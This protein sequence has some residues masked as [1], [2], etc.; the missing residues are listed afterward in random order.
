MSTYMSRDLQDGFFAAQRALLKKKSRLR[1]V[2]GENKFS[3]LRFSESSF[4]LDADDTP[5]LRGLVDI[6]DGGEH[7]YQALIVASEQ[8]GDEVEFEF[9]RNT[10]ATDMPAI[11]FERDPKA[12]I[13]LLTKTK[14]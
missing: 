5:R 9:K 4:S 3:I 11:D 2:A 6:Y 7:L 1:V 10:I 8:K 12:P 13:A 14:K